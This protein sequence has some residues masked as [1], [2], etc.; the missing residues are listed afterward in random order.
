MLCI[1]S[2]YND[3]VVIITSFILAY[4]HPI[5]AYLMDAWHKAKLL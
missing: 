2:F 1:S 3:G 4:K 5:V